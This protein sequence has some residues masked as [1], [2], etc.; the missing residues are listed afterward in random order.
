MDQALDFYELVAQRLSAEADMSQQWLR[1]RHWPSVGAS[2]EAAL[3]HWIVDYLPGTLQCGSGFIMDD[4]HKLSRQCDLLVYDTREQ[5]P[6]YVDEGFVVVT[7]GSARLVV[8]VKSS[9]S[10]KATFKAAVRNIQ[11]VK[12]I[13]DAIPGAIFALRSATPDRIAGWLEDVGAGALPVDHLFDRVF[14]FNGV[15]LS[16]VTGEDRLPD[17]QVGDIENLPDDVSPGQAL[18]LFLDWV[19]AACRETGERYLW[20]FVTRNEPYPRGTLLLH[21]GGDVP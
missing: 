8:E 20:N 17:Q 1:D 19:I 14:S 13:D 11:S 21:Y 7:P 4:G 12:M 9:L 10:S 6:L 5:P 3:R 18:L 15:R 16:R 2:R